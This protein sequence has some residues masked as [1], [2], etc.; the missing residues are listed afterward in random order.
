MNK[1]GWTIIL[2]RCG[3]TLDEDFEFFTL[4]LILI[5]RSSEISNRWCHHATRLL[6]NFFATERVPYVYIETSF[7]AF[8]QLNMGIN[9]KERLRTALFMGIL[10]SISGL[11]PAQSGN[12]GARLM[13][14]ASLSGHIGARSLNGAIHPGSRSEESGNQNI[15]AHVAYWGNL[16]F[17]PGIKIGVQ[18]TILNWEKEKPEKNIAKGRSLFVSPNLG[19]YNRRLNNTNFLAEGEVGLQTQR[20]GRKF[21]S[22]YSVG[23]GYLGRS[24]IVTLNYSLG[25][26]SLQSKEREWQGNFLPTLN[27]SLGTEISTWGAW[28]FKASYGTM[29]G[30]G[31]AS[32]ALVF[33]ELGLKINLS[34]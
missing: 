10:M 30:A 2:S 21:F 34:N 6:S 17:Q 7:H 23:L 8:T 25:D 29:I 24:Q 26:G 31:R 11:L 14:G 12:G 15:Q 9:M 5:D 16:G 4:D 33:T 18:H 1:D 20:V 13:D 28:Y 19:V 22:A 32:S 27:Y 3:S